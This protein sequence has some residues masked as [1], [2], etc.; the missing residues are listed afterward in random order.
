MRKQRFRKAGWIVLTG[1]GTMGLNS[2]LSGPKAR[3][4]NL[5]P[6][7]FLEAQSARPGAPGAGPILDVERKERPVERKG[8]GDSRVIPQ[9]PRRDLEG[10]WAATSS[11]LS[12]SVL[13]R[14]VATHPMWLLTRTQQNYTLG[15]SVMPVTF[16]CS[17]LRC[18]VL[19]FAVTSHPILNTRGLLSSG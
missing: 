16:L 19:T 2:S 15:S 12:T 6:G 13:A 8:V 14:A 11:L 9:G 18:G 3:A 4:S 17:V 1:R 5:T 7:V 10:I